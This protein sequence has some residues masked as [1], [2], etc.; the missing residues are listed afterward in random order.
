MKGPIKK[1]AITSIRNEV[2]QIRSFSGVDEWL[3]WIDQRE[4]QGI[5]NGELEDALKSNPALGDDIME[6][7]EVAL[8]AAFDLGTFGLF[9]DG[10]MTDLPYGIDSG[11]SLDS[12]TDLDNPPEGWVIRE[13]KDEYPEFP[14]ECPENVVLVRCGLGDIG[15]FASSMVDD[16]GRPVSPVFYHR[17]DPDAALYAAVR[18]SELL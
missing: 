2:K 11:N 3:E 16:L 17:I 14:D 12:W 6:D 8:Q 9:A 18:S 5:W 10:C 4:E 15:V 13:A 7:D 1:D